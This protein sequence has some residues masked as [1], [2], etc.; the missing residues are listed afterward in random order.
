VTTYVD[1]TREARRRKALQKEREFVPL[2]ERLDRRKP[3]VVLEIGAGL[4]GTFWAFARVAA[5]DALLVSVDL[6]NQQ[7]EYEIE[8]EGIVE[9]L[10]GC[11]REGQ[12]TEV[13]RGDSHDPEVV[14]AVASALGREPVVDFLFVDGDHSEEGVEQD[15][16]T[17]APFVRPGGLIGFHDIL[18]PTS[19]RIAG[20]YMGWIGVDRFWARIREQYRTEEL[21]DVRPGFRHF[22]GI[23]LVHWD[24]ELRA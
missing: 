23:G 15:F 18:P 9:I 17:Y 8:E 6:E 21:V 24:G 12:R 20:R 19:S 22:G 5:D 4:G 13:I 11:A 7:F 2:L 1:L 10:H 14:D 3:Q 16:R